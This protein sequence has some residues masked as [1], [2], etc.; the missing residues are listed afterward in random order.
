MAAEF[1]KLVC[2]STCFHLATDSI[3]TQATTAYETMSL[4]CFGYVID[5]KSG[6]NRAYCGSPAISTLWQQPGFN[7]AKQMKEYEHKIAYVN[8]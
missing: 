4:Q 2:Y 6:Q 1:T 8:G 3:A 5:T 7:T